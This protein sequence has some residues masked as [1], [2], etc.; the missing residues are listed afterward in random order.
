MSNAGPSLSPAS[1]ALRLWV[2][3]LICLAAS[4]PTTEAGW[5]PNPADV[6]V[7]WAKSKGLQQTIETSNQVGMHINTR[8]LTPEMVEW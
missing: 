3:L 5:C 6:F 1:S 8:K 2:V 4:A 7:K